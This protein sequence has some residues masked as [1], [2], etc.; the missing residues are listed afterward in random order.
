MTLPRMGEQMPF[1]ML[2][3]NGPIGFNY[4]DDLAPCCI[5]AG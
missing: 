1:A 5:A 4:G 2:A 3:G